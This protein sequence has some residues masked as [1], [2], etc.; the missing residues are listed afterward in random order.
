V[1]E[2]LHV[3]PKVVRETAE[4]IIEAGPGA[5]TAATRRAA[6]QALIYAHE[7]DPD[8]LFRLAEMLNGRGDDLVALEAVDRGLALSPDDTRGTLLKQ[9]TEAAGRFKQQERG[10]TGMYVIGDH[11]LHV[12]AEGPAAR[13]G[14][15]VGD[16]IVSIEG[17]AMP[18]GRDQ[19]RRMAAGA[20]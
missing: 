10:W 19:V 17:R 7:D 1:T 12:F 14:L 8:A 13:S 15:R 16:E 18:H 9:F 6:G 3:S 2:V 11:V 4:E 5:S 20:G